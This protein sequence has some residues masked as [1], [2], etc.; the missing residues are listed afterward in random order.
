MIMLVEVH[1]EAFQN[2]ATGVEM[3]IKTMVNTLQSIAHMIE[4][5]GREFVPVDTTRLER[6]FRSV[7]ISEGAGLYEVELGYSALGP[8]DNYDYAEY[9][10][11]GIDYRTGKPLNFQKPSAT[12]RYLFKA[13][14]MS[15]AEGIK[16]I[17]MDYLS[18]FAGA[19][20]EYV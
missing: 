1:D 17:E 20:I 13:V 5:Q 16:M 6:S 11:I 12:S 2:W 4:M 7:P 10:H 3:Q 15:E 14:E 9:V 18:L 8:R 19:V